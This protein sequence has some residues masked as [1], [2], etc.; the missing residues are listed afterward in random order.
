MTELARI[1]ARQ[2]EGN[3]PI[4]VSRFMAQALGHPEL[5]YYATRD[6]LGAEGDFVTAPEV[7]QMFGEIIGIW[8]LVVWQAMGRPASF[9]LAELGPGR[10]T[11]MADA[12]RAASTE[13]GFAEAAHLHLVETSP[14]LRTT[15]RQV[16][17]PYGPVFV[18]DP[19]D[20]PDGPMIVIANEF[21]DALPIRQLVKIED[22]WCERCVGN[23]PAPDGGFRFV[24]SSPLDGPDLPA[25]LPADLPGGAATG[26]V[27]EMSPAGRSIVGS[28]AARFQHA[29]GA[30]LIIDYGHGATAP[31]DTLQA[32]RKHEYTD[33]LATPGMA[34]L[35]AHVDF[36]ALAGA[37]RQAGASVYGPVTQAR[38]LTALGLLERAARL[39]TAA[40]GDQERAI[41]T[42]VDR[43]IAPSEMGTLF[44][45]MGIAPAGSGTLPGFET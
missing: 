44:K 38:F 12:L 18:D 9:T 7:S 29:P 35:T 4:P 32:V 23:Q 34:D 5:G 42:A 16:L 2:I 43:L 17:A 28:L 19:D 25:D 27:I 1:I 21:F 33:P 20:L 13:P 41:D 30:L 45:V 37:A 15:Q 10:G 3:G 8:S 14:L 39:K 22:G 26:A 24:L 31:G 6:P 11:L 40:T 36:G